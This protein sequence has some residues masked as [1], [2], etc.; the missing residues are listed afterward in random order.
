MLSEAVFWDN[1]RGERFAVF[2]IKL[3]KPRRGQDH[4]ILFAPEALLEQKQTP[5]FPGQK[6][7]ARIV[8]GENSTM[9]AENLAYVGAVYKT[10]PYQLKQWLSQ[11]S[12][13]A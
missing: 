1:R 10:K 4:I 3:N 9:F 7:K 8:V 13:V 6:I 2:D 5:M 11:L 12:R